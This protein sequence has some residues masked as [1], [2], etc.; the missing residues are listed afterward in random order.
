MEGQDKNS[1]LLTHFP[2]VQPTNLFWREVGWWVDLPCSVFRGGL[3]VPVL[4]AGGGQ[5]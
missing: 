5:W 3:P 2:S 4:T 1:A